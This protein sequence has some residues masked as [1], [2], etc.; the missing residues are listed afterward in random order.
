MNGSEET[1]QDSGAPTAPGTP[2]SASSVTPAQAPAPPPNVPS[3][4]IQTPVAPPVPTGPVIPGEAVSHLI[5]TAPWARFMAVLGFIGMG[6]MVLAGLFMLAVGLPVRE[7]APTLPFRFLGLFYIGI[8]AI[9]LIPLLP[10]NRFA[11]AA[12]RLRTT[13]T[14]ENVIEALRQSRSFWRRVGILS[15]IGVALTILGAIGAI[16]VGVIAVLAARS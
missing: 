9:Y 2:D 13:R 5:G 11:S 4:P 14:Y 6:F 15:I 12:G 1:P 10:L 8:A 3:P 7:D 16:A